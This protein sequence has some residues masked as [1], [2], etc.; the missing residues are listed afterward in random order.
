MGKMSQQ[1]KQLDALLEHLRRHREELA[2]AL[3]KGYQDMSAE[4]VCQ[5]LADVQGA[6]EAVDAVI[7]ALPGE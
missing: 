7:S 5:P 3:A 6:I 4:E 2:I 1:K